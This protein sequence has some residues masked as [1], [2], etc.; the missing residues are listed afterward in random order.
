MRPK[1]PIVRRLTA[2]QEG[3]WNAQQDQWRRNVNR[4]R[5]KEDSSGNKVPGGLR[6]LWRSLINRLMKKGLTE[7]TLTH[8][9]YKLLGKVKN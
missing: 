9:K 4:G 6:S 5:G 7:V 2:G 1:R 8:P 3:S